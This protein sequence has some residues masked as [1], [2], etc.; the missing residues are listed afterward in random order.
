MKASIAIVALAALYTST[1]LAAH[2]TFTNKHRYYFDVNG[3]AIDTY[4]GKVQW[5]N[6]QYF[7]IGEPK[8]ECRLS[9]NA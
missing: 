1:T 3:N 5:I 7:W 8:C 6:N 9:L 2:V 4:N